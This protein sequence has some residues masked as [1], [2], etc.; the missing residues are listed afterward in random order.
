[1]LGTTY[2]INNQKIVLAY[3][4]VKLN[5]IQI[6]DS[7]NHVLTI[8]GDITLQQNNDLALGLGVNAKE[9]VL[10]KSR[11]TP[12]SEFFG[13][14]AASLKLLINGTMSKPNIEG[15]IIVN[16][17]S[18]VT[19]VLP[20]GGYVKDDG[21]TIVRFVD[22]DTF[23][24]GKHDEGF[25]QHKE[26]EADF[27][28]FLKYNLNL[29]VSKNASLKIIIDP[30]TGDEIKVQGD[31]NLNA[32]SD[33]GGNIMITGNYELSKGYYTLNY[34]L[35]KRQ[36]NLLKGSKINFAGPVDDAIMDI[37]AE[38]VS[39]AAVYDLLSNEITQLSGSEANIY[40]Q[41]IPFSV[42]LNITGKLFKPIISFDIKLPEQVNK[43]S[44]DMK[45]QIE[46]KLMQLRQDPAVMNK[47]VFSLLLL[48]RFISE[49]SSDFLKYNSSDF[50]DIAKKSVSNF[51]SGA[52]NEIAGDIFKGI[53]VD[54]NLN[55][56]NDFSKGNSEQRTDLNVAI[57]KSFF[58]NRLTI[59]V[60]N[61]FGLAGSQTAG[62][63]NTF[64]P[65]VNLA[66]KLSKD[67]K[68][69]L[70]AYTKN[71]FEIVLD[72]YV[73]ETGMSFVITVDYDTF[74]EFFVNKK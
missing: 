52:I 59:S 38:Y 74:K 15:D 72:G 53:D 21:N 13:Y 28:T 57:S 12:E 20:D 61:N 22:R 32:L 16:D 4:K 37:S 65:D 35:L 42:I 17:K 33:P 23:L 14:A 40:K 66:Y 11:R 29:S 56:Y 70:K 26:V 49:Q 73:V 41:K 67:G 36:F 55:S 46:N 9:F 62:N 2:K 3:P 8:N 7:L 6:L 50:S 48:N 18:D 60:G 24:F 54:L 47:Q 45:T 44:G 25:I 19:I 39:N 71:Q 68:Y 58:N 27:T 64:R 43:I 30:S 69:M 5:N 1:M 34:Q 31:A 63:N 10:L 51:L